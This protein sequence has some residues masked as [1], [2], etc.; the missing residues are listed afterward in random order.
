MTEPD[1][2]PVDAMVEA[3]KVAIEAEQCPATPRVN[4]YA[5]LSKL[6]ADACR[7]LRRLLRIAAHQRLTVTL[8]IVGGNDDQ[9]FGAMA[10]EETEGAT[11]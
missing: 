9:A 3:L 7:E 11:A 10:H 6:D 2:D 1:V 8:A 5:R 4:G